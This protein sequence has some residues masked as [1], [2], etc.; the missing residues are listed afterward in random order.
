MQLQQCSGSTGLPGW[1]KMALATCLVC[2]V[3]LGSCVSSRQAHVS[4]HI[5]PG[6]QNIKRSFLFSFYLFIFVFLGLHPWHMEAPRLR[7][8]MELKLPAYATATPDPSRVCDLHHSSWQRQ[9]LNLLS[10]AKEW[11]CIFMDA[12][13]IPFCWATKGT[14]TVSFQAS[15]S[16]TLVN[17]SLAKVSQ[18]A[19]PRISVGGKYTRVQFPGKVIS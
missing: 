7:V 15:A 9:I 4:S 11:T 19:K 6:H 18:M 2:S 10:E 8:G 1:C 14:P 16:T 13:Q 17:I 5:I 3:G 12:S